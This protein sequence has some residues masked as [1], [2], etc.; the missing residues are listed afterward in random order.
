[1]SDLCFSLDLD[2]AG[3]MIG[4]VGSS[5]TFEKEEGQ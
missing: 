1:M 2:G 3:G 5:E 4:A